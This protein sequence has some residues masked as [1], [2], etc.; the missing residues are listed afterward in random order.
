M[1]LK[2]KKKI[3]RNDA[4]NRA[5]P[6]QNSQSFVAEKIREFIYTETNTFYFI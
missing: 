2:K 1:N 4:V 6:E 3:E 5:K